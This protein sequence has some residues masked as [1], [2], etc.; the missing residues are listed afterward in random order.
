MLV[1]TCNAVGLPFLVPDFLVEEL[2]ET[3]IVLESLVD[4]VCFTDMVKSLKSLIS[5][6]D[7][8]DSWLFPWKSEL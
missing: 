3:E 6:C 4:Y 7:A 1:S 5:S 8:A 2:S